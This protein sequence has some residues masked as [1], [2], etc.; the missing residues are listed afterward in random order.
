MGVRGHQTRA[1]ARRWWERATIPLGLFSGLILKGIAH[2][3]IGLGVPGARAFL[4][5][6]HVVIAVFG[7]AIVG[8]LVL[9]AAIPRARRSRARRGAASRPPHEG[10]NAAVDAGLLAGAA[11]VVTTDDRDPAFDAFGR[12]RDDGHGA[13]D[14]C[15]VFEIGSLTKCFTGLLL[16]DMAARGEARLEERLGALIDELEGLPAADITLLDVATHHSGLPRLPRALTWRLARQALMGQRDVIADPYVDLAAEDVVTALR[17]F[18]PHGGEA[19]FRYSNLGFAA[20][21]LALSRAGGAPYQRLVEDRVCQPLGLA[22]TVFEPGAQREPRAAQGHDARGRPA[23]PW[24]TNAMAPAGGLH[25]TASDMAR[26][27]AAF[28]DPGALD[29][30]LRVAQEPR[31]PASHG[32]RIGLG[33]LLRRTEHGEV[34]WHNGGTGGFGCFLAHARE[35]GRGVVLLTNSTHDPVVDEVGFAL[36]DAR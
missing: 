28:R 15:T 12:S 2:A 1:F 19:R 26:F 22:D 32:N 11:S 4:H 36:L 21:G 16:A 20:L 33:W 6:A 27:L 35:D 31:R 23:P 10:V 8:H 9:N 34:V 5:V 3:L 24:H 29:G 25:S 30:A 17:G 18:T 7:I 14:E 13:P